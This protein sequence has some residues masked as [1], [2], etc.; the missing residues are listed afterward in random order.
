MKKRETF[1]EAR[2]RILAEGIALGWDVKLVHNGR[3]LKTP[4][5][6]VRYTGPENLADYPTGLSEDS[7]E[8]HPQAIYFKN[9]N[10]LFSD[11]REQIISRLRWY[12]ENA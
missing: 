10:S 2:T 7:I 9:G 8:F 11:M 1:A 4:W 6:T 3:T 12:R 5:A